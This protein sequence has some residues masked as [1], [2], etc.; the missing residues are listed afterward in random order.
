MDDAILPQ[1]EGEAI[2]QNDGNSEA[3]VVVGCGLEAMNGK[4]TFAGKLKK[5]EAKTLNAVKNS[6]KFEMKGIWNGK[7]VSFIICLGRCG[8]WHLC[9]LDRTLSEYTSYYMSNPVTDAKHAPP[10]RLWW[11][12]DLLDEQLLAMRPPILLR[13]GIPTLDWRQDPDESFS[14]YR[15]DIVV[16]DTQTIFEYN[17]H[18]LMIASGSEYFANL[19]S[20]KNG[21]NYVEG[22]RHHSRIELEEA[23]AAAFPHLLD[24]MYWLY[25]NQ[26]VVGQLRPLSKDVH[27]SLFWLGDYFKVPQLMRDLDQALAEDL[28]VSWCC[29]YLE[30]ARKLGVQHIINAVIKHCVLNFLDMSEQFWNGLAECFTASE[31]LSIIRRQPASKEHSLMASE[32]VAAFCTENELD[33]EMFLSLTD[34]SLLPTLDPDSTWCLLRKESE[35]MIDSSGALS[36]LQMRCITSLS[37]TFL[38]IDFEDVDEFQS[39]SPLFQRTLLTRAQVFMASEREAERDRYDNL[40]E[41]LRNVR[42]RTST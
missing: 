13:D 15:I 42:R 1:V 25:S 20:P 28:N 41:Q 10:L 9:T 18:K 16:K 40:R 4:Y 11:L 31:V 26:G 35:L 12:V 27:V 23:T 19:L 34:E 33:A 32:L 5:D 38:Y 2:A 21:S 7:E 17:V 30:A 37:K 39:Q 24:Y 3:I 14:D 22:E 36:N 29:F 6:A 8:R